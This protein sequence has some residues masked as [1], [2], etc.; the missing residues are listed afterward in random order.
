[1]I[2]KYRAY[3]SE[4]ESCIWVLVAGQEEELGAQNIHAA[5]AVLLW[6]IDANTYEEMMAI[7]SLRCGFGP[8]NPMGEPENCPKCAAYFYPL[9]SG[10]CWRCGKIC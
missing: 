1:M 10:D 5:D 9:G 3:K 2:T 4:S 7:H 8:Y 6:E